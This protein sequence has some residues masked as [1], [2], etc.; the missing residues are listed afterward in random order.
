MKKQ[1]MNEAQRR[2]RMKI[3]KNWKTKRSNEGKK[4]K[5]MKSATEG[6]FLTAK[7]T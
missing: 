7:A 6:T 3:F 1:T 5:I 2:N 4:E